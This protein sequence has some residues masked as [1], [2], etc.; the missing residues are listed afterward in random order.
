MRSA[1]YG[2]TLVKV[3]ITCM[4]NAYVKCDD[5]SVHSFS[6]PRNGVAVASNGRERPLRL[7][8][9][10]Q[11]TTLRM[12]VTASYISHPHP[13]PFFLPLYPSPLLYPLKK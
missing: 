7:S 4:E 5:V 10:L 1:G 13:R 8:I 12:S 2:H 11:R 6:T 9:Q 3:P